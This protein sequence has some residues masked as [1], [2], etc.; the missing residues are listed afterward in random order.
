MK[1]SLSSNRMHGVLVCG[2]LCELICGFHDVL[3]TS[4]ILSLQL[5]HI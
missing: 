4:V 2:F 1:C 5:L 3:I